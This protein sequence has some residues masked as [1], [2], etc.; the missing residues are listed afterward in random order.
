[1]RVVSFQTSCCVI[2]KTVTT[3]CFCVLALL[4][5]ALA[6]SAADIVVT[7]VSVTYTPQAWNVNGLRMTI[8]SKPT[9][10]GGATRI[11]AVN[12]ALWFAEHDTGKMV[13]FPQNGVASI[14]A[15]PSSGIS[16]NAVAAGRQ[17]DVWFA[18]FNQAIVGRVTASGTFRLFSTGT[19][20]NASNGMVLG[21]DGNMWFA[22]NTRGL[23]RTTP[24]GVTAFF[25]IV[26]NTDQPTTV[27]V[28]GDGNIW[29]VER[30]GDNVGRSTANGN[31]AEFPAG[32]AGFS[33][34][35]GVAIGPDGRLWFCDTARKRIGRMNLNGSGLTYFSAGLTGSP[36]SIVTGPDNFL[37]FGE[38]EGR[39]G[40]ISMAGN[41]TEYPI[42]GVAGTANFPVR[43]I[44]VG[45]QGN[46]WF[47]NDL[48][49]QVGRLR[50]NTASVD[51]VRNVWEDLEACGW[52]GPGNSGYPAGTVFTNTPSRTITVDGTVIDKQKI[53]GGLRIAA[54]NVV[55]K[56]SWIIN[57]AGGANASGVIFIEPGA[58]V[59]IERTTL[60][61]SNATHA[62]IW[63]EGAS[64][65]A[66]GNRIFGVNDGIFSW[67]ADNFVIEDNYLHS[68][69]EDAA[70]GHVDGFQTEGASNG[71]IRHNT[72]DVTQGQTSAIA[73]WNDRRNSD[74]I[75]IENNLIAGGGFSI[76]AHDISPSEANPAGGNTVTNIRILNNKFSTVH[77]PCVG[78][79]GVWF[80]RG[81]PSDG[82][83]RLGN[84][85][86]ETWQ[87]IDTTNPIA[88]GF[89]CR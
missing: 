16:V 14:Y 15:I 88:G 3:A 71:V 67:D 50:I 72:F 64:M 61:G 57:S 6:G 12:N 21:L 49:S 41:I 86:L 80:P 23:G 78:F 38:L 58:T 59:T 32:F 65:V 54:K 73:V 48:K 75:L 45:P 36:V 76:Y 74:N 24:A 53:T 4:F 47:V 22:S 9:N 20:N 31:I 13:R 69:T 5:S 51:C 60:D 66:R 55:V 19:V 39:I 68:F 18:A 28:G 11:A 1:M 82:W 40:R 81:A 17:G 26:N 84:I 2:A 25:P 46:I 33:N 10:N 43:G 37:Y 85:V 83:R 56:N 44:T 35:F 52:P 79:Y 42:P 30:N 7:P 89:L 87:K 63:Y 70:N 77:Y 29:Y 8:W 34:S 27:A 62:G